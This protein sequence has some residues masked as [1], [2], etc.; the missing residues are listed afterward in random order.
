MRTAIIV[1]I[2]AAIAVHVGG[3]QTP[4]FAIFG[5]IALLVLVDF[6]GNRTRRAVSFAGL[7]VVGYVLITVG[8]I[9]ATPAWVGVVSML[10]VGVVVSYLAILSS[11]FAA[12]QRAALLAFVLPVA[13]PDVGPISDRLLGWTLALVFCIPA[14]LYLLPPDH[15]DALRRRA[16]EVCEVLAEH[17]AMSDTDTASTARV[18]DAMNNLRQAYLGT[19]SRPTGLTAGSRALARVVDDLEWLALRPLTA[20]PGY[21]KKSETL[22]RRSCVIASRCSAKAGHQKTMTCTGNN[23]SPRQRT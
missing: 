19:D 5:T 10:M 14:A 9:L 12:G 7:A 17:I 21:P 3:P 20:K 16:R 8:T 11:S 18:M 6:P 4:L 2:V 22:P 15:H 1:P 13:V 23:S